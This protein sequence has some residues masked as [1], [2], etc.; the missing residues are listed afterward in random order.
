[1][2][3]LFLSLVVV[4]CAAVSFPAF[5][6]T[7]IAVVDVEKVLSEADA[8]KTLN[9]KRSEA[10]EKFLSSLSKQEQSLREEGKALFEKRNDLAPEEFAK[11]QKEYEGKLLEVRKMTQKQKRVF[12]EA[13]ATSLSQLQDHL[14]E[15]VRKIA[16]DKDYGI[17][18][19]NRNVIAGEKSLDITEETI[20]AMNAKK[21]KIPFDVKK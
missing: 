6:Q 7:S 14:A 9:K 17:V 8:A 20:K 2:K 13:S 19:S 11:K 16:K 21:L 18:I 10:R 5:A 1:M 4:L 15:I 3:Q 12:E